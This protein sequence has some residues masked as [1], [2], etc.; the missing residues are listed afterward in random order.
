[1]KITDKIKGLTATRPQYYPTNML[2]FTGSQHALSRLKKKLTMTDKSKKYRASML[3]KDIAEWSKMGH[4]YA[5]QRVEHARRQLE[6]LGDFETELWVEKDGGVIAPA[7]FWFLAETVEGNVHLS[8]VDSFNIEGQRHYQ[9]DAVNEVMKYKRGTVVLATGLGKTRALISIA[10]SMQKAGKRTCIIV[11]TKDLVNQFVKST[12]SFHDSVTG[13]SSDNIPRKGCDILI[14]TPGT[15]KKYIQSYQ[16][17]M[18][19]ESHHSPASTWMDLLSS[20]EDAEYVY[21]FTATP[22][23]TDG[24]DAAIHAFGGPIVYERDLIWGIANDWLER[25]DVYRMHIDSGSVA[26]SKAR[27]TAYKKLVDNKEFLTAVKNSLIRSVDSGRKVI[28]LFNTLSAARH[29]AKLCKGTLDFSIADAQYK[30]PLHDFQNGKTSVLVATSKLV[31]EG[32]DIPGADTL[33]LCTQNSSPVITFQALGRILRK[34]DGKKPLVLDFI[35]TGW[36][37]FN[38]SANKRLAIWNKSSDEVKDVKL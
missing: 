34:G 29:L 32:I 1:M 16:C 37:D 18:V 23:R 27:T 21:N 12:K 30:K 3:Q 36:K 22:F 9:I 4:D 10:L 15:A 14:T 31:G 33:F 24:M 11:P 6:E 5:I 35:A 20:C 7:G 19:D 13:A 28:V 25:F 38:G 26:S 2:L 17:V 8:D